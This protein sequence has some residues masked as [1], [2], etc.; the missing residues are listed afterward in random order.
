MH[1][2]HDHNGSSRQPRREELGRATRRRLLLPREQP[3]RARIRVSDP[4]S[5]RQPAGPRSR[6]S[7]LVGV[8]R[9]MVLLAATLRRT[10]AGRVVAARGRVWRWS[11]WTRQWMG[12]GA[13][14]AEPSCSRGT[15]QQWR[16]ARI[17]AARE[18]EQGA[19]EP[20]V[21]NC[22]CRHHVH[23]LSVISLALEFHRGTSSM[24]WP[25]EFSVDAYNGHF[26]SAPP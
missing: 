25:T 10:Q 8:G 7:G 26:N 4:P 14:G 3:S 24:K 2:V 1:S 6:Y 13:R 19:H 11:D 12:A 20:R 15:I 22:T 23:D 9:A 17:C 16:T 21:S 5:S 18:R